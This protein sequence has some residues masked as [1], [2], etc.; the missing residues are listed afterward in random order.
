M[1]QKQQHN[2]QIHQ[3][4]KCLTNCYMYIVINLEK[5]KLQQNN[6]SD[7]HL[8]HTHCNPTSGVW[9]EKCVRKSYPY[10]VDVE[11]VIDRPSVQGKY[12]HSR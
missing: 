6:K 3:P 9:K 4:I 8:Q 2:P 12:K 1:Q 11:V 7:Y 5:L 10:F